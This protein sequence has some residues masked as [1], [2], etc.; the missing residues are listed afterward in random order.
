MCKVRGDGTTEGGCHSIVDLAEFGID[1]LSGKGC[2][3]DIDWI[4][5]IHVPCHA[6]SSDPSYI[7]FLPH[8]KVKSVIQLED[9]VHGV[10]EG[11]MRTVNDITQRVMIKRSKTRGITL[12]QEALVQHVVFKSLIRGGFPKG[13]SNVYEIIGLRDGTVCFTME[14]MSG[15]I[16]QKLLE[17][18]NGFELSKI[19]IE[20]LI[21][22]SS[23]LCHI[24]HDI[25]MNHRDLKPN[26][27]IIIERDEPIDREFR[28]GTLQ[29]TM[30]STFDVSFIDFGFSCIGIED[31]KGGGSLRAGNV[32]DEDDPCPK[33]GRDMYMFLA[34]LY[35]NT[36]R[37][38]QVDMTRLFEKWLN[39]D[40]SDMTGFLSSPTTPKDKR[41]AM[42]WIYKLTGDPRVLRLKTTPDR[43]VR[44]LLSHIST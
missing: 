13:A 41:S 20:V 4:S 16:L 24:I 35:F 7:L 39:V 8:R 6:S 29:F 17:I 21:Y 22:V 37:K 30:R 10:I 36:H 11:G 42:D 12:L 19:I 28:I 5:S 34:F 3:A 40:G 27:I 9:G 44:D 15:V 26:N 25:G 18:R 14:P 2:I 38:L 33:E 31:G 43:I 32:Y 1:G 23:M